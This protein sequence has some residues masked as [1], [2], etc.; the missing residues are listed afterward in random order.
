[1]PTPSELSLCSYCILLCM[2]FSFCGRFLLFCICLC[3]PNVS[4][5]RPSS[6]A[7][8]ESTRLVDHEPI[9]VLVVHAGQQMV[10]E[11]SVGVLIEE[12]RVLSV[13]DL[14]ALLEKLFDGRALRLDELC[15]A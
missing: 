1:M 6:L 2:N 4:P 15:T 13:V 12:R 11:P 10:H 14:P 7:L 3:L 9:E 5:A 8:V